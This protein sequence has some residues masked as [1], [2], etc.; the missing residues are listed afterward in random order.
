MGE[1][2]LARVV[3][4]FTT[5]SMIWFGG[6]TYL[7]LTLANAFELPSRPTVTLA[8]L[9]AGGA[10]AGLVHGR[11]TV[12]GLRWLSMWLSFV[13]MGLLATTLALVVTAQILT[14]LIS[15]FAGGVSLP[16]VQLAFI[17]APVLSVLSVYVGALAPEVRRVDVP[18]ADLHVDLDGYRI[19][20]LADL[21]V[22]GPTTRE[23][24]EAVV[25]Q[26]VGLDAD[27][28]AFAGDLVDGSVDVLATEVQA[29]ER[30]RARDGAYFV[31]GNHE[32]Y[33]NSK[34][35]EDVV[36]RH[37]LA[38]LNNT[39][40]VVTVGSAR[41]L[42]AGVTDT[43][44]HQFI[45]GDRSDPAAARAGSA[46]CDFDLLLAHQPAAIREASEAGY[47][48]QVSGHTHGGQFFPFTLL[49]GLFNTYSRGLHRHAN[50]WI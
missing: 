31:T 10:F 40:R 45:P 4:F 14:A 5:V 29:L 3:G 46:E 50:T 22:G 42:V 48:L 19:A 15:L 44:A 34:R 1:A 18:Q 33:S 2:G 16:L 36:A 23:Q 39:H 28:I 47:D 38:V 12:R 30:L 8:C 43:T 21:H 37:G 6:H 26:V 27:L 24:F 11:G 7:G 17:A 49:V 9:A 35:W 41:L 32:Y 13:H 20:L 25:D